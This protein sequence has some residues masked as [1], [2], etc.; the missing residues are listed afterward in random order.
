MGAESSNIK[1]SKG[2]KTG[3]FEG[4]LLEDVEVINESYKTFSDEEVLGEIFETM[5]KEEINLQEFEEHLTYGQEYIP[6]LSFKLLYFFEQHKVDVMDLI[7]GLEISD[8][9]EFVN[10]SRRIEAEGR[11]Q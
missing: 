11:R 1:A 6:G 4:K 8:S 2:R 3:K 10:C 7:K 9:R 5:L